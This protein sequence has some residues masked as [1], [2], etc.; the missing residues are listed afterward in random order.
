MIHLNCDMGERGFAHPDDL[1]LLEHVDAINIAC[2]G[3]AG[4]AATAG[5]LAARAQAL[6]ISV[7][8]HLSYP[9]R[10]HFGRRSLTLPW[11]ELAAS[12]TEQAALLP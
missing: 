8:A 3:H 11:S 6:G 10:V 4:D 12:L 2:G 7:H 1:A 5:D 9:D